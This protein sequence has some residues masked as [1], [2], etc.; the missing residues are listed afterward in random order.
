MKDVKIIVLD[1]DPTG[2]QTVHDVYVYTDWHLET[3]Q[4]AFQD[5]NNLFFILTNS[6]SF[7]EDKTIQ[8]HQEIGER[9]NQVAQ[10]SGKEYIVISRGDSTLRG[11][12]PLETETLR[13]ALEEKH[14]CFDGEIFCPFF[15]EGGRVTIHGVHYIKSG[16]TLMPVAE[17]EFAKDK[18]FGYNHSD[19]GAFIE[20]KTKGRYRAQ[21]CIRIDI[22][23]L[24]QKRIDEIYQI[25]LNVDHFNKVIVD[26]TSYEEL[27]IFVLAFRQALKAGKHFLIRSAAGFPKI[28][29]GISN[30]GLLKGQSIKSSNVQAGG[31]VL[32][33]S[34][35]H[36]TTEQLE[37]LKASGL[38][39]DYI[40]F[41]AEQVKVEKG[42][43]REVNRVIQQVEQNIY[44]GRTSV[45]YTSRNV[46]KLKTR[47]RE[48]ILE[49]SVK[50]SEAVT[51]IIGLIQ[52]KP[53]FILAKGGITSSDVGTKALKVKKA[54]VMGQI[55]PGVPVWKT[56]AKS[57]FPNMPY[58]IFPGNVGERETLKEIIESLV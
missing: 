8:V 58:I 27:E 4:E 54:F 30:Q 42:L 6:R 51:S 25:L 37:Y 10:E 47:D 5:A 44:Q 9:I 41:K 12:Y 46:V 55:K 57:K 56:D 29:G 52:I 28:L 16:E 33:G 20:E 36:K 38:D 1:D 14:I 24:R 3:I 26:S 34:H 17:S 31:I 21:D 23:L 13:D 39:V 22:D 50:I 53:S 15:L 45:V 32:I 43:K 2:I 35:V 19:L 48:K 7:S 18:T 40:E 49:A 11:H